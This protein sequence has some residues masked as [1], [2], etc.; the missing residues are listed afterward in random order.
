[1]HAAGKGRK[2]RP[3]LLQ[4]RWRAMEMLATAA[5]CYLGI[6]AALFSHPPRAAAPQDFDWHRQIGVFRATLPE[7]LLWPL[8]LWCFARSTLYRD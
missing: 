3:L 6:G 2:L 4:K 8:A 5:L 7:V 1:L